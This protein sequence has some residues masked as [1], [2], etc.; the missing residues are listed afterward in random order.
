MTINLIKFAKLAAVASL[1]LVSISI[2]AK[3]PILMQ[4]GEIIEANGKAG[5][6]T[7]YAI[8]IPRGGSKSLTIQMA[9]H[10]SDTFAQLTLYRGLGFSNPIECP[11][12][13]MHGAQTCHLDNVAAGRYNLKVKGTTDYE[14]AWF[15]ASYSTESNSQELE[16]GLWLESQGYTGRDYDST[17]TIPQGGAS[18]F[19]ITAGFSPTGVHA[20]LQFTPMPKVETQHSEESTPYISC[21]NIDPMHPSVVQCSLDLMPAGTYSVRMHGYA[22]F[23]YGMLQAN[24]T[25]PLNGVEALSGSKGSSSVYR[26]EVEQDANFVKFKLVGDLGNTRFNVAIDS[27]QGNEACIITKKKTDKEICR[28]NNVLAGDVFYLTVVAEQ[29]FND[30]TLAVTTSH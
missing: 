19:T 13:G 6:S 11:V 2:S 9:Y 10:S 18:D 28:V 4:N 30:T 14:Y 20:D 15:E 23:D 5:T 22:D 16:N 8:D 27:Q 12:S 24:Y 26:Y 1:S 25:L 7:Y 3:P 29:D 17:V 21:P